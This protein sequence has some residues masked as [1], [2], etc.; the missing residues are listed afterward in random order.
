MGFFTK[1][2]LC[3]LLEEVRWIVLSSE[4]FCEKANERLFLALF[5]VHTGKK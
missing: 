2:I 1:N 3:F 5:T 4:D